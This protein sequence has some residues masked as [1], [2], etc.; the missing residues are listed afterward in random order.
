MLQAL[1]EDRF[2]LRTH[3]ETREVPVYALTVAQGGSNLT[4]FQV[5]TC[6]KM[7]M[8]VPLPA[9]A[10]GQ[11]YCKVRIG[12]RAVDAQGSI[13]AQGSTLAEFAHMLT[14]VLDRPVIDKTRI[15][16]TF[17]IHLEFAAG[18]ASDPTGASI[19]TAI[20]QLGLKLEPTKGL[21]EFL[22]IDHAE[23]P[24]EN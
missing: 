16:G 1:L 19:L 4:P 14:L 6:T 13:E 8:K 15:A 7:P 22:V 9:L 20:Q 3:R 11:E 23:R 18:A 10:S 24:T 21:R 2:E 5:G 17:D 12:M